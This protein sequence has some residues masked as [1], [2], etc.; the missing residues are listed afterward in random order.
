ML[1]CIFVSH[2]FTMFKLYWEDNSIITE[3]CFIILNVHQV[4]CINV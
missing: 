3:Y 1:H 2:G 4:K